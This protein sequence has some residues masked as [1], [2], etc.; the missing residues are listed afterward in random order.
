MTD[1][2]FRF[3][4]LDSKARVCSA[5]PYCL[6]SPK[7]FPHSVVSAPLCEVIGARIEMLSTSSA[8]F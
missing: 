5:L 1:L 7:Y 3:S 8:L 4:L 2:E 6:S